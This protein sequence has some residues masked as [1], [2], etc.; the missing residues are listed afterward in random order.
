MVPLT[1]RSLMKASA[2]LAGSF[3]VGRALAQNGQEVDALQP[4]QFTWTPERA[5]EGPVAIIV[6][7]PRQRIYIYRNGLLIGVSTCSTGKPGH[8]TPTGVF[9]VLQKA[10]THTSSEYDE[11]MP[12]MERLTW[13]GIAL[14]VGDLPGYPSSHGCVHLPQAFADQ[15]YAATRIGTPVIIAGSH[16]EPVA[17][18]EPG[19]ILGPAA[20]EEIKSK[21]GSAMPSATA[22]SAATSVLVSSADRRIYVMENEQIVASGDATISDP[23]T[24]LGSN[25][26][27]WQGGD[28][29]GSTWLAMGFHPAP[30]DAAVPDSSVLGRIAGAPEV[31]NAIRERLKL[32]TMLV[33]TDLPA[34]PET[35]SAPD[36]TIIDAPAS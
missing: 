30:E 4:G 16:S 27:I 11:A 21:L 20:L 1:R 14:H 33:T 24:P 7:I 22:S 15:V 9:T 26:F 29:A 6:S 23:A 5:P 28:A 31:M 32:G 2:V 12:D 36:F 25:I 8:D 13:Q 35:R 19:Q 10:K 18:A 3:A 17:I 34:S